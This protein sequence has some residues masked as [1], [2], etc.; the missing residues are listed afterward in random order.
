MVY[1]CEDSSSW[2]VE[3]GGGAGAEQGQLRVASTAIQG[4]WEAPEAGPAQQPSDVAGICL[5]SEG[6]PAG[7]HGG[8]N[9]GHRRKTGAPERPPH[10]WPEL[11]EE[12]ETGPAACGRGEFRGPGGI[13]VEMLGGPLGS[14]AW[15]SGRGAVL[16]AD[17][18]PGPV[19]ERG[20]FMATCRMRSPRA[21]PDMCPDTQLLI[22]WQPC[23]QDPF[24][25]ALDPQPQPGA[26]QEPSRP[27][28][29][30]GVTDDSF[31]SQIHQEAT[32]P[33]PAVEGPG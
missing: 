25:V 33:E 10:L 23:E 27:L 17:V 19:G 12:P 21:S 26:Q 24:L 16:A 13:P 15:G 4:L 22:Q 18:N 7:P 1:L 3:T 9:T 29:P 2:W 30:A 31:K 20:G 11:L 5:I 6:R 14:R 32:G 8:P 28:A